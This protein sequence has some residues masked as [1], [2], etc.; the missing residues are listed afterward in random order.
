MYVT[1][2]FKIAAVIIGTLIGAGFAS[3]Q[4]IYL[5]FQQFGLWGFLGMFISNILTGVL[6]YKILKIIKNNKITT[7]KDFVADIISPKW[8]GMLS[9]TINTF[10][11]IS[12]YIMIAA[13]GAYFSQEL[14]MKAYIG[15]TLGSIICFIVFQNNING[16]IK[17]NELLVPLLVGLIIW[18]GIRN[19]GSINLALEFQEKSYF[20]ALINSVIYSSY[21]SILLIP[22]LISMKEQIGSRE[23]ILRI[24]VLVVVI[25]LILSITIFILL[26]SFNIIGIEIPIVYIAGRFG[27]IYNGI[28]GAVILIAILTSAVS[29]GY[30]VLNTTVYNRKKY[31]YMNILICTTAIVTSNIGFSKLVNVLYPIFGYLGIIQIIFIIKYKES[32]AKKRKYI[33]N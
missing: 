27:S 7:Y 22:I 24:S 20:K 6:I 8:K 12:F 29:I 14:G 31:M 18:L 19:M 11:L 30:G 28:Y 32:I 4:E 21:N 13:F 10:L 26:N 5:F 16:V 33:Y 2:I 23:Q 1:R 9:S 25:L 3:G 17:I 15:A